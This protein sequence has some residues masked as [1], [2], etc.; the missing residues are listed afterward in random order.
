MSA[1]FTD[2]E[3][4]QQDA[5][6]TKRA[7]A[8]TKPTKNQ[9]HP[10]FADILGAHGMPQSEAVKV[11]DTLHGTITAP[12]APIARHDDAEEAKPVAL[13]YVAWVTPD[14]GTPQRIDI[15]AVTSK[16][17]ALKLAMLAAA[18]MFPGQK[19]HAMARPA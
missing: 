12:A 7:Q 9:L 11:L 16:E 17:E 14:K 3:M 19:F 2:R 15:E 18:Q 13:P 5:V 8:L 4:E 10:L 6:A 1:P